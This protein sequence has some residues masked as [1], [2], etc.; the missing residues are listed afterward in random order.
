MA[1]R[2][3]HDIGLVIGRLLLGAMFIVM[4]F[5]KFGDI[6]GVAE[7][8][9]EEGLPAA[10]ALAWIAATVEL[11]GGILLVVGVYPG[12]VALALA[13]YLVPA[14]L[15]FHTDLDVGWQV[16]NL[17]KNAGIIGGLLAIW[18]CRGGRIRLM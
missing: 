6:G 8:L 4:G 13:L 14:T 2:E 9:A 15:K 10:T 7:W 5:Y 12:P 16:T 18:A 3:Q 11:G 1:E 17:I